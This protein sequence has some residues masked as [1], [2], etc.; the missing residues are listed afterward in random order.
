MPVELPPPRGDAPREL[1]LVVI[2]LPRRALLALYWT[3]GMALVMIASQGVLIT[4]MA[5]R[6]GLL[7]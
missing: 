7:P 1:H 6:L 3:I 2:A 4:I 5:R